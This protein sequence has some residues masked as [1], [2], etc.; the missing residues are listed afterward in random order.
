LYFGPS[1][2]SM[3]KRAPGKRRAGPLGCSPRT[4]PEPSITLWSAGVASTSK[5]RSAGASISRE[6]VM[7]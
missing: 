6:R 7:K 5:I 1:F 3:P 2:I 4:V